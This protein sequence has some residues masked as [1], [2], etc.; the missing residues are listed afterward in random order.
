M[1]FGFLRTGEVTVPS[2]GQY[3]A[4][5]HLSIHDVKLDSRDKPSCLMIQ[6]KASK[7]DVFR[8]GSTVY[9][10][11]TGT[12]LCP[13]AAIVN[14]MVLPRENS[15]TIAFFGFSDGQPLTRT[16]FV[17]ELC[18]ALAKAGIDVTKFA[19]HI[20]RIRAATTAVTCGMSDSLIQ[21]MGRWESM[22]YTLYIRTPQSVL[23]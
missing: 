3:D 14:Y 13:V 20:F 11:I 18:T 12:E 16:R 1:L 22:A 23:C 4:E 17:K 9:L 6:I 15:R 21:T 19:G 2:Q 8:K 5:V 7:T 10:G